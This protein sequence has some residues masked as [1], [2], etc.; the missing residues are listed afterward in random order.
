MIYLDCNATTPVDPEVLDLVIKYLS[1]EFGNAGSRTHEYG[2]RAQR[3]VEKARAQVAKVVEAKPDEVVFT[4]GATESNNIA[5]LGLARFG[6]ESGKKHIVSTSIE[7]KAVLEPLEVLSGQGFDVTLVAP[8]R[9]GR[10][11]AEDVLGS[12]REDTLLVSVMHVNNETGVLQPIVEIAEGLT[13]HSAFFHV[14]AAQGFG[15]EIEPLRN[16][17]IDLMS[18]SGHKVFS[19]KGIGALITRYRGYNRL[20]LRPLTYGGGQE[21]GLRPGTLPVHLI[22]GLGLA[23]ELALI[24]SSERSAM[25]ATFK[26]R[27][28][29]EL[30]PLNPI[31]NGDV[32]YSLS[33]TVNLSFRGVDSEA[34]MLAVKQEIA[35]SNG[36]ACTSRLYQPSH[37]LNAMGLDSELIQGA[38]RLSWC[39]RTPQPD[40]SQIRTEIKAL[41]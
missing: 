3:A 13:D 36:S 17:R 14:D 35:I 21:A 10:V 26:E 20:P 1:D 34:L 5:I 7:H 31:I 9:N 19:P 23:S 16:Q 30:L 39:H 41:I 37:V 40:W 32:G 15:K 24:H 4:S 25:C 27:L 28:L 29:T 12:V 38:I 33:N 22:A 8:Q 2:L 6:D 11:L 18:V